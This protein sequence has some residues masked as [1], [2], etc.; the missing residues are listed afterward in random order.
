MRPRALRPAG[1]ALA[2]AVGLAAGCSEEQG[3]TLHIGGLFAT[4]GPDAAKGFA[5]L[6]AARVAVQQINDQG[7]VLGKVCKPFTGQ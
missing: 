5:Q 3:E 1:L 2:L 7:G 4:T 6:S